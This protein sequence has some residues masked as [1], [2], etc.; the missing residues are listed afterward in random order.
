MKYLKIFYFV[1]HLKTSTKGEDIFKLLNSFFSE[2]QLE[3]KN[4]VSMCMDGSKVMSGH[5]TELV[6]HIKKVSAE[7]KFTHCVLHQEALAAKHL[8]EEL[9]E[10][11]DQ[12]TQMVQHLNALK[13][14]IRE[15]FPPLEKQ[16]DW[17]RDPFDVDATDT[18]LTTLKR[19]SSLKSRVIPG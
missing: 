10:V 6:G 13:I 19:S 11:L 2:H 4:C 3:W 17:I 9:K 1:R 16:Y 7:C 18:K 8:S 14:R 15:Y 12:S 5:I